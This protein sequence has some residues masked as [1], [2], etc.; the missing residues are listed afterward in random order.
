MKHIANILSSIAL[1]CVIGVA[2][3]AL[4]GDSVEASMVP[5]TLQSAIPKDVVAPK[6]DLA[7]PSAAQKQPCSTNWTTKTYKSYQNLQ[8]EVKTSYGNDGR[9]LRV[10]LCGEGKEAFFRVLF[11][12]GKG[13]VSRIRIGAARAVKINKR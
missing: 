9:I 6:Q 11:M 12:S 8:T 13:A 7:D 2:S 1:A 4:A 10:Y 5:P 3:P